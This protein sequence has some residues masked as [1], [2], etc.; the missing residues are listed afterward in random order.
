MTDIKLLKDANETEKSVIQALFSRQMRSLYD[1]AE[2]VRHAED[3]ES[4]GWKT[5]NTESLKD[6]LRDLAVSAALTWE[7]LATMLGFEFPGKEE[8]ING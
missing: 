8:N 4:R 6:I 5:T 3:L 7:D 2:A 1:I